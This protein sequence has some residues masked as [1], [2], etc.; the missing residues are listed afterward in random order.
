MATKWVL[1]ELGLTPDH[2]GHYSNRSIGEMAF[3]AAPRVGEFLDVQP[4]QETENIIFEVLAVGHTPV[5]SA[6][7]DGDL[8]LRRVG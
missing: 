4:E 7:N 1:I 3:G 5:C 2:S 6:S 8:Y